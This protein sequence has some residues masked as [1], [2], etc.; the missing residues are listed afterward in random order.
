MT[1][2]ENDILRNCPECGYARGENVPCPICQADFYFDPTGKPYSLQEIE[3]KITM[4][5]EIDITTQHI[6]DN[7]N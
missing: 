7:L 3:N 1:K 5:E 4:S 6:E 2:E